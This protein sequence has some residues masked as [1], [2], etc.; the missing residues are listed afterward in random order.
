M[1]QKLKYRR[2]CFTVNNWTEAHVDII[3]SWNTSYCIIGS[4]ICPTTGTPHLQC[5]VQL[6][7]GRTF[8]GMCRSLK[9]GHMILAKGD[10]WQNADYCS[11]CENVIWESGKPNNQGQRTDLLEIK[12]SIMAG[13]TVFSIRQENPMLY[14][15][16]GRTL[17]Q[18]E[19]DRMTLNLRSE[20]TEGI[21]FYGPTG[22][23]KSREAF[24]KYGNG[25]YI[26]PY[27]TNRWWDTYTQQDV[28]IFDDF[29]G[30]KQGIDLSMMCRLVDRSPN[31]SVGHRGRQPVPFNSKMVVVTSS[32]P[33][34]MVYNKQ[35]ECDGV[36]Q[37]YRRFKVIFIN[38]NGTKEQK[39]LGN[40]GTN[41]W[42][43]ASLPVLFDDDEELWEL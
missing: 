43:E 13:A 32:M 30:D 34:E 37:L 36:D 40:N 12:N 11:K 10:D 26:Y 38:S 25:A 29:R 35:E 17:N 39:W 14:H 27:E 20:M 28:V 15:Q 22:C 41:H 1:D 2:Y 33:P 16:Y 21:W 19:D 18:L 9:G 7:C 3:K 31:C 24:T 5:Y 23:G 4:E 8:S 42:T 6:V